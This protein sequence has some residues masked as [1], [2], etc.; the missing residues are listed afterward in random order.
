M[1]RLL[2]L[3]GLFITLSLTSYGQSSNVKVTLKNGV[4]ITGVLKELIA[5]DHVT[6]TIS[7]VDSTIP[8]TDVDRIE[9]IDNNVNGEKVSSEPSSISQGSYGYYEITE[10]NTYPET[11]TLE[12]DGQKFTMVLVKGGVFNMGYDDRHSLSM[13]SEPVHQV[14]LSSYYVSKECV[15]KRVA[16]QLIGEKAK[17]KLDDCY[18]TTDWKKANSLIT[19]IADNTHKPYRMLT[20]AEW[21][22]LSLMPFAASVFTDNKYI[23]WCSDY[24]D[25][26]DASPQINPVGPS[27]GKKHVTRSFNGRRNK[28]DRKMVET[29]PAF[30][31]L[32]IDANKK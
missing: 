28:W 29:E 27:K 6:I 2:F 12:L 31:R 8:M 30:V 7:G 14:T 25:D 32:V 23:E 26:Y 19:S 9:H 24:F 16:M 15:S 10:K 4:T 11:F 3:L 22:Y 21:E 13:K 17:K 5:T 20:E 1:K 18:S